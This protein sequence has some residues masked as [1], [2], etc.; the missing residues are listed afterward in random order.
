MNNQDYKLPSVIVQNK[1][2]R[3]FIRDKYTL[4]FKSVC[5]QVKLKSGE[6]SIKLSEINVVV[7]YRHGHLFAT[8]KFSNI[9]SLETAQR[10]FINC[11][12]KEYEKPI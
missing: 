8:N 3:K 10:N 1:T 9:I 12:L 2:H 11:Y 6:L 5:A 4:E 7:R